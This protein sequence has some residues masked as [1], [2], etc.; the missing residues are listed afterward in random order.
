MLLLRD[1]KLI[2]YTTFLIVLSM[3]YIAKNKYCCTALTYYLFSVGIFLFV[4]S[5][6]MRNKWANYQMV[7]NIFYAFSCQ[8]L[9]SITYEMGAEAPSNP[10]NDA[11][12]S[13]QNRL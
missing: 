11:I 10:I 12:V 13:R 8:V 5:N 1:F 4:C 9:T 6:I 7:F 2:N 3:S